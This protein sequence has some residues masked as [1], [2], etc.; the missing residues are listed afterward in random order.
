MIAGVAPLRQDALGSAQGPELLVLSSVFLCVPR[1]CVSRWLG[2]VVREVVAGSCAQI[3]SGIQ[4][5]SNEEPLG[6]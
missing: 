4:S 1:F 5:K 3:C 2:F 6:S